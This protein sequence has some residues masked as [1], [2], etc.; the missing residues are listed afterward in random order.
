MAWSVAVMVYGHRPLM[1]ALAAAS[2]P[3]I[4]EC[5]PQGM[6][7]TAWSFSKLRW[8]DRPL[9]HSLSS[10]AI[11][12]IS[13]FETRDL[14]KIAWSFA[15]IEFCDQ[16]LLDALA[17]AALRQES[18][19]LPGDTRDALNLSWGLARLSMLSRDGSSG[20]KLGSLQPSPSLFRALFGGHLDDEDGAAT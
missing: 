7:N 5:D 11:R 2:I 19:L 1:D 20:G 10:Q 17:A 12:T 3:Q 9:L 16:P 6:G 13:Q 15:T 18:M 14:A 8:A 4:R